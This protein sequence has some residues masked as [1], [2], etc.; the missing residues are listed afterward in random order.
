MGACDGTD[1]STPLLSLAPVR[2]NPVDFLAGLLKPFT[3]SQLKIP[4]ELRSRQ[5]RLALDLHLVQ[6]Q[7]RSRRRA[8]Q[9]LIPDQPQFA[10][11]QIYY[12]HNRM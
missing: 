9:Q 10:H 7:N 4:R 1:F 5:L 2:L 6:T 8:D 11:T 12:M 3:R